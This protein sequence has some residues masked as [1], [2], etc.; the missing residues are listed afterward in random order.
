VI[1]ESDSLLSPPVIKLSSSDFANTSLIGHR[2]HNCNGCKSGPFDDDDDAEAL[3]LVLPLP[4]LDP[5]A[6]TGGMKDRI[7]YIRVAFVSRQ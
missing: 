5:N 2:I 4:M 1:E 6:N 3:L 7:M